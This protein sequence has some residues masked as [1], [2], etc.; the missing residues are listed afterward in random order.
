MR[1]LARLDQR[2]NPRRAHHEAK[3]RVGIALVGNNLDGCSSMAGASMVGS[4]KPVNFACET[5]CTQ[6][7]AELTLPNFRGTLAARSNGT[8]S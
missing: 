7:H 6:M 3:I 8:A 5:R 1:K 2:R 4:G